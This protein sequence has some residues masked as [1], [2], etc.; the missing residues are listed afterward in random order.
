MYTT[1]PFELYWWKLLCWRQV[2]IVWFGIRRSCR[3]IDEHHLNAIHVVVCSKEHYCWVGY[4]NICR[5][6]CDII[7]IWKTRNMGTRMSCCLGRFL[8][9]VPYKKKFLLLLFFSFEIFGTRVYVIMCKYERK[10]LS[11]FLQMCI[12][13]KI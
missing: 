10:I 12:Q 2:I 11:H 4:T 9:N 6:H 8:Y 1:E 5:I 7:N 13:E 3:N